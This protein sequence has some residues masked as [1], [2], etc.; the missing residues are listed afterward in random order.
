MGLIFIS[1]SSRDNAAAVAMREWLATQGW[2]EVF[3]DLDPPPAW[4]PGSAGAT[5]CARPASAVRPSS[6]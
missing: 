5:S 2:G 6:C 1:H 4:H 3:L